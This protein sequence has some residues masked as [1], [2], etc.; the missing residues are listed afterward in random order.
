MNK[1]FKTISF[2]VIFTI[3]VIVGLWL[4][5]DEQLSYDSQPAP[6]VTLSTSPSAKAFKKININTASAEQLQ[7]L[8]GIGESMSERIIDFRN[9]NGNFEVIEDI[10]RVNGIGRKT[11]DRIKN[12]IT[13]E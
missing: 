12:Y 6:T 10:M 13:T 5:Y 1:S 8:Y 9:E 3:S 11:F 7:E 2:A 4:D